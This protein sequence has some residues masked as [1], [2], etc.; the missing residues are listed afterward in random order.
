[1]ES[2]AAKK[3]IRNT[4]EY[5]FDKARF[6]GFTHNLFKSYEPK[7]FS[8]QGVQIQVAYQEYIQSYERLGK[9]FDS[10]GKEID[11]LIVYLK[12]GHTPRSSPFYAKKLCCPL[13]KRWP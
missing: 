9:Y 3:L 10:E 5:P 1:M 7:T 13:P 8:Y 11:I 2:S 4:F 12:K 6:T